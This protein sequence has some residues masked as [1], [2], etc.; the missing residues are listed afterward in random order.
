MPRESMPRPHLA[1]LKKPSAEKMNYAKKYRTRRSFLK[2]QKLYEQALLEYVAARDG[3]ELPAVPAEMSPVDQHLPAGDDGD[4]RVS[5]ADLVIDDGRGEDDVP[6]DDADEGGPGDNEDENTPADD[7]VP[8]DDT[9]E[10]KLNFVASKFLLISLEHAVSEAAAAKMYDFVFSEAVMN[11]LTTCDA[12]IF[13]RRVKYPC[14]LKR[15]V[16]A[17]R[18][19]ITVK[20]WEEDEQTLH[21]VEGYEKANTKPFRGREFKMAFQSC[22]VRIKDLVEHHEYMRPNCTWN[23]KLD[24]AIDGVQRSKRSQSSLIVIICRLHC[25]RKFWP[26]MVYADTEYSRLSANKVSMLSQLEKK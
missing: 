22:R 24:L 21:T 5:T 26:I 13:R 10:A 1:T 4:E 9:D 6:T 16:D 19:H 18:F 25:C 20:F 15:L 11:L 14:I 7:D 23:G 8:A 3:Y 17:T 12:S 2:E